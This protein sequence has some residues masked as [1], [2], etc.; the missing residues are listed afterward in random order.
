VEFE[1]RTEVD[2]TDR[3]SSKATDA[4]RELELKLRETEAR[5]RLAER[6]LSQAEGMAAER[7]AQRQELLTVEGAVLHRLIPTGA[8][9]LQ[10]PFTPD[11]LAQAVARV[12][13]AA[14]LPTGRP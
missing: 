9:F 6:K 13:G 5:L 7:D 8:P 10:K 12:L 2:R 4:V 14:Q 11:A 3:E 1:A